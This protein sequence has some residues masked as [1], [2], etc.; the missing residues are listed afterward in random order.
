MADPFFF[1]YGSL[2]N[3]TTHVY[4]DA[5]RAKVSGWR[6]TWRHT[7]LHSAPF[8]T[9]VQCDRTEIEGL[10]AHVP[11]GDWAALDQ[12]ESGY[13]RLPATHQITHDVPR[14]IE[15]AIY[16]VPQKLEVPDLQ[17][18]ILL[19]YLDVVIQGY[20]REF[21]EA[22]ALRFFETTDGWDAPV[23]NDRAAPEY[24]RHRSL[25]PAETDFVDAQLR[26]LE[27]Q[28]TG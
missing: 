27:M 13:D 7:A 24:P 20:L 3:R 16:A 6:R 25:S 9:A 2:V 12:R 4:E 17:H 10:I 8:L 11:N 14:D 23:K 5:H 28:F 18:P 26:A 21:G 15:V 19:S 1:G 22:G